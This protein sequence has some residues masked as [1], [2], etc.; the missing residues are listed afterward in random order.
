M[1]G[2]L[3]ERSDKMRSRL[4]ALAGPRDVQG[5]LHGSPSG[6]TASAYEF[7]CPG[8]RRAPQSTFFTLRILI[9]IPSP[10]SLM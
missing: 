2:R 7:C 3:M 4:I 6:M 5:F 9:M 1:V 10:H 8:G